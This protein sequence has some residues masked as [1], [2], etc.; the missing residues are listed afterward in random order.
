[1]D[2][3]TKMTP[4]QTIW[5]LTDVVVEGVISLWHDNEKQL[6]IAGMLGRQTCRLGQTENRG[7]EGTRSEADTDTE[8]SERHAEVLEL[9]REETDECP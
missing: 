5:R 1:M 2:R 3:R 9:H 7:K 6:R 8:C 4:G